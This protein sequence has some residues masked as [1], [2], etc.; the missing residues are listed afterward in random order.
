MPS[1]LRFTCASPRQ[2]SL[3]VFLC[4]WLASLCLAPGTSAAVDGGATFTGTVNNAT[5]GNFLQGARVEISALCQTARTDNTG[6]TVRGMRPT[7]NRV[8]LDRGLLSDAGGRNRQFQTHSLTGAMF[9]NLELIKGHT[10]NKGADSLGGTIDFKTRSPLSMKEKRCVTYPWK[11]RA[12]CHAVLDPA[13]F[14]VRDI[15]GG[16]WPC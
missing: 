7:R 6:R 5:A 10:P 9:E 4:S 11:R 12:I 15:A 13:K 8:T 2:F 1:L 16:Q 14:V 3:P